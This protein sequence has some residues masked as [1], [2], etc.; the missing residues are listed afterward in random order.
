MTENPWL[1]S[2]L[3]SASLSLQAFEKLRHGKS[4]RSRPLS[5]ARLACVTLTGTSALIHV[6]SLVQRVAFV[7]LEL[8]L[9]ECVLAVFVCC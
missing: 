5:P 8:S 6:L 3:S 2:V 9:V 1:F 4:Q 7:P